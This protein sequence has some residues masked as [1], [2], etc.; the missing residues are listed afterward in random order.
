MVVTGLVGLHQGLV[1][2]VVGGVGVAVGLLP[3]VQ[4]LFNGPQVVVDLRG[5]RVC[6]V[7]RSLGVINLLTHVCSEDKTSRHQRVRHTAPPPP[8]PLP[9]CVCLLEVKLRLSWTASSSFSTSDCLVLASSSRC[10]T[11]SSCGFRSVQP[12]NKTT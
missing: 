8:P 6:Q 12:N 4:L 5:R 2:V 7:G 11:S 9:L 10:L 3:L 1:D